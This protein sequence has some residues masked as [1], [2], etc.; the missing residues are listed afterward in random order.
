MN[1]ARATKD[2][3][4]WLAKWIPLVARDLRL[5]HGLMKEDRFSFLRATFYRWTQVWPN[6]CADL[7]TAPP[8]LAVG[9]LHVENFGT[10]H[11]R[12]G[13]LIWGIN[14]FDQAYPL[15][16]PNDLVR[17]A[18]SAKLAIE[19]EHLTIKP[20][21]AY[22]AILA[23]YIEG[24]KTGGRPIVLDEHHPELREIATSK[25]RNPVSFWRRVRALSVVK[26]PIPGKAKAALDCLM[27]E[28]G[29]SYHVRRRVSGMGSLGHPR[30][31][32][33]AEWEG[34]K[35]VRETKALAPSASIWVQD[36]HGANTIL[37]QSVLDQA[38]RCRDPFVKVEGSWLARRLAPYCSRIELP[39]LP[40][41]RNEGRLLYA[42]GW[43][44]AN[45]HLGTRNAIK[46][47]QRDLSKRKADWLRTA[48]KQMTKVTMRDWKDWT[49]G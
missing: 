35:I 30:Y 40:K 33:I 10:W 42:M 38:V 4:R 13:R 8:V 21:D 32:A 22:E 7:L 47:V 37:Y 45:V 41:K 9:D 16:Y 11:D 14:D 25:L 15:P 43:E 28:R 19:T 23:G 34:G 27:P 49:N 6:V 12:E 29:L 36:G 39:S 5:K 46:A 20:K 44:T 3:E 31:V 26:G 17:V 2:Y 24:L 18:V 48:T 1:I